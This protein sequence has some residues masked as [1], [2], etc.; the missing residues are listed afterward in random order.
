MDQIVPEQGPP[1]ATRILL[2][3]GAMGTELDRLGVST[4]GEAWSA[5]AIDEHPDAIRALHAAYARA[6]ATIHTANTFRTTR[7]G[8]GRRA[9]A[10]T[11]AAVALARESVP[12]HHRVAGSLAPARDCYRLQ[13]RPTDAV[14]REEHTEHANHLAAAG[15]DLILCETFA[16]PGE[17]CIAV[18]AALETGLETWVALTAGYR[19]DLSDPDRTGALAATVAERGVARVLVNCVPAVATSPYLRTVALAGVPVGVYANAGS[20]DD[21]VGWGA[22]DGPRRYAKLARRWAALGATVIGGC[23]GTSPAHVAAVRDALTAG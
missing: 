11:H 23:C 10:L 5:R 22:D 1:E 8:V 9:E 19:L 3:D 17:T 7:F 2:L 15:V 4:R 14:A 6:G 12:D 20:P 13:D 21:H 18:D 16:D